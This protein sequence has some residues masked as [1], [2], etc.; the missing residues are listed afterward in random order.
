MIKDQ[1][2]ALTSL[3]KY[4]NAVPHY[5]LIIVLTRVKYYTHKPLGQLLPPPIFHG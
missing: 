5:T 3:T 2:S 4:S 1:N